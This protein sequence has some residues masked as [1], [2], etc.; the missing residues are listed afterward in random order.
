MILLNQ[1]LGSNEGYPYIDW[2]RQMAY[3]RE[4]E[5]HFSGSWLRETVSERS[6]TLMYPLGYNV[7]ELPTVMHTA[8]L[9]GE[10]PDGALS[11]VDPTVEVW[12]N[13][14]KATTDVAMNA[15]DKMTQFLRTIWEEND[16]RSKLSV[17]AL[18][19]QIYGG[20]TLGAFYV[21]ERA[22]DFQIPVALQT[23]NPKYFNPVWSHNN[24]DRMLQV[25]V[26]Y[27]ISK[28]QARDLGVEIDSDIGL[29]VEDWTEGKYRI[30]VDNKT[31]TWYASKAEGAPIAH[32]IPYVYIPHPPRRGFYGTSLLKNKWEMSKE[33]NARLVD[34]GD[35]VSEE[36]TNMPALTNVRN[37]EVKRISGVKPVIDLG[38]AQ[39]NREPKVIYPPNRGSSAQ[40]AGQYVYSLRDIARSE[41]YC[42]PVVFGDDDGSQRSAASLALRA[43]PLVKHIG[44]ERSAFTTAIAKICKT[45]LF[46]AADK[47]MYGITTDMAKNAKVRVGWYPMMPRDVLEEVTSV[48]NRVQADILSPETAITM[49]GGIIDV[50][51]EL[52]RIKTWKK[53]VQEIEGQ[54]GPAFGG[55]GSSGEL[56][57]RDSN[58]M[59][60]NKGDQKT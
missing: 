18:D 55:T 10:V 17:A 59:G 19:S 51:A 48:I 47:D 41:A 38:F 15:A 24:L 40:S 50:S 31:V 14:A 2:D 21:P 6:D 25:I 39:G 4:F 29:Y 42:P 23:V 8:F 22:V 12:K 20:C 13:G 57:S 54:P 60:S 52:S 34:V 43:I 26:A 28:I 46:I 1:V 35:I 49:L 44:E 36:A 32:R 3:Y 16:S 45:M 5:E 9:F 30:S 11:S 53:Q 33:I 56:A 7:F 58:H 37:A 27:G